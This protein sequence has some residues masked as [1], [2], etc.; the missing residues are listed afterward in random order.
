[1]REALAGYVTAAEVIKVGYAITL[2]IIVDTGM[3]I[4]IYFF[5]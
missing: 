3:Y 1:M 5:L 2:P 4:V